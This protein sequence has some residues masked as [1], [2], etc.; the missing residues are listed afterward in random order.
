MNKDF[1]NKKLREFGIFFSIFFT[2]FLGFLFPFIGGHPFKVW[3]IFLSTPFLIIGI[4]KPQLLLY[5][6]KF[7]MRL[8][9]FLGKIN[10][11]IILGLV[12]LVVL[13]PISFI[14]GLTGYDPLRKKK[15]LNNSFRENKKGHKTDLKRIF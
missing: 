2:F 1:S 9:F 8:G 14:M 7:W 12:Y 15:N 6:F 3:P 4:L 10:S 13:I 11:N 5:P